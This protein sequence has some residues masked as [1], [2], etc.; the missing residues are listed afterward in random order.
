MNELL[1]T[2]KACE[3]SN[4]FTRYPDSNIFRMKVDEYKYAK[5]CKIVKQYNAISVLF[6]YS[7]LK[8][9]CS[10]ELYKKINN[11]HDSKLLR[12]ICKEV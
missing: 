11:S 10:I 2:N 9:P 3:A 8:M 5:S 4:R 1:K 12:K 6:Y 7:S